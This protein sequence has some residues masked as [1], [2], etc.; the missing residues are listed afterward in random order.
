MI[1]T[2]SEDR[3]VTVGSF[4]VRPTAYQGRQPSGPFAVPSEPVTGLVVR[5]QGA[6]QTPSFHPSTHVYGFV[7]LPGGSTRVEITDPEDRYLPRALVVDVPDRSPL[8]QALARGAV[9]LPAVLPPPFVE[10]PLRPSPRAR[11]RELRAA[12][13][14]RV[15]TPAGEPCPFAWVRAT[16]TIGTYVTYADE[17]G[18]YLAPLPFLRP[19]VAIVNAH[20]PGDGDDELALTTE[21]TVTMRAYRRISPPPAGSP[22]EGFLTEIDTASPGDA[23]FDAVYLVASLYEAG[24]SVKL[25]THVRLDLQPA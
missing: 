5:A 22:L 15:T 12:V 18:D 1:L 25:E 10:A 14:G 11:S 8:A 17:R 19:I 24:T 3:R 16:T 6:R 13:F 4:A 23:A 2:G 7:D 20:D 21:F 9:S